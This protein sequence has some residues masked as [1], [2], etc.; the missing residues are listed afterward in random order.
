MPKSLII[1]FCRKMLS[2][3]SININI[4]YHQNKK[5]II[6]GIVKNNLDA[7]KLTIPVSFKSSFFI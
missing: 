1:S 4:D 6:N 2:N 3:F 7:F 5:K